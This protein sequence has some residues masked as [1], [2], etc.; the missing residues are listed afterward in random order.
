MNYTMQKYRIG[1]KEFEKIR[2][3]VYRR[4]GIHLHEGKIPLVQNRLSKRLRSLGLEDFKEYLSY[5]NRNRDE[6]TVMVNLITTNYTIFF[7]EEEHFAFLVEKVIPRL[8]D[9]DSR[10]RFWSAGCATGEEAYSM[11]MVLREGLENVDTRDVLILA[12]DVSTRALS[13]A[14]EGIYAEEPVKRCPPKYR[15][16]YFRK[17]E[18]GNGYRVAP[19]LKRMI[20]FRYLNLFDNWP[21][22]GPFDVIFCRNVMIYFERNMKAELVERFHEILKPGGY[23]FIGHSESLTGLKNDFEYVRPSIYMK[24]EDP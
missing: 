1:K 5:L 24:A 12:T 11:A 13:F 7:R 14:E 4:S 20:R 2:S 6:V 22:H 8:E 15:E 17:N 16:K 9:D 23:F 19:E 3:L 18:T 10:I 21:M